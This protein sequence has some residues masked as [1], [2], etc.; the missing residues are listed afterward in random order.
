M[1]LAMEPAMRALAPDAIPGTLEE[2]T[3]GERLAVRSFRRWIQGAVG[4]T[5]LHGRLL[6]QGLADALGEQDAHAALMAL[7]HLIRTLQGYARRRF[8]YHQ[9]C[10]SALTL[11]ELAVLRMLSACQQRQL[12]LARGRALWLVHADGLCDLLDAAC[13]LAAVFRRH[14]ITMGR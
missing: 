9:P 8:A 10:C 1:A 4:D 2:L 12:D 14:R 6:W 11:D 3:M 7:S 5:G 13:D